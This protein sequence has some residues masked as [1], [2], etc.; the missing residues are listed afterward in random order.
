MGFGPPGFLNAPASKLVTCGCAAA[1]LAAHLLGV[2]DDL[3]L[4]PGAVARLHLPRVLASHVVFASPGE[5]VFGLYLLYHFRVFERQRGTRRYAV[6]AAVA[7]ALAIAA[8]VATTALVGSFDP[9][10]GSASSLAGTHRLL[11]PRRGRGGGGPPL[12]ASGPHALIWA[13]VAPFRR[14][15][16]S[17]YHFTV[18]G[19]RFSD[20][21]FV[22][23]AA[24]QLAL[25]RWPGGVAPSLVGLIVGYALDHRRRAPP[26]A[27]ASSTRGGG[28]TTSTGSASP[29]PLRW[30]DDWTPPVFVRRFIR[31][32]AGRALEGAAARS[33]SEEASG[34]RDPS[35]RSGSGSGSSSSRRK[36]PIVRV[37]AAANGGGG[38]G[39]AGGGVGG[40]WAAAAGAA[41]APVEVSQRQVDA[42]AAMGFG[43]AEARRALAEGGGDL[44][45]ATDIL[46]G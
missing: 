10:G 14:D 28:G 24:I 21:A 19:V 36:R 43:E 8:Q 16:P 31:A 38:G 41:G 17:A 34:T 25:S 9:S 12:L 26:R 29:T 22:Y 18:F 44:A 35:S 5:A 20:K 45:R 42:L 7:A 11:A 46:L 32:T 39:G 37:R 4:T 13:H 2:A 1:T 33:D 23:L 6:F 27:S 30:V 40:G 3:A 15:V